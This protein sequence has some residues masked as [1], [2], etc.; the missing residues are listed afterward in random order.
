MA[1]KE[2]KKKKSSHK[3][4]KRKQEDVVLEVE[5]EKPVDAKVTSRSSTKKTAR[6]Q[7]DATRAIV[8]HPHHEENEPS[9]LESL[10][11]TT[12]EKGGEIQPH[13]DDDD[14]DN[15]SNIMEDEDTT[16][17]RRK[18]KRKRA[19]KKD[20]ND[21]DN[22]GVD[23]TEP[24]HVDE[25]EAQVSRTAYMEGLP[26]AAQ[27]EQVREF[28]VQ[29]GCADIQDLRLPVWQD[30]GRLRG[31]GHVVFTTES[32]YHKAIQELTGKYIQGRYLT[33]QPALKPKA[34][35]EGQNNT[36]EPSK[37]LMLHNL[38]YQAAEQDIEPVLAKFGTI[39][40]GGVRVVRHSATGQSKGFAYVEFADVD[41]AVAVMKSPS[42]VVIQGRPCR[43]DYDHGRVRGSFRT[44]DRKLWQKEHGRDK[45]KM[46]EE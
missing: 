6:T 42:Q 27:P 22:N 15:D 32:S 29:H 46:V 40:E 14:D 43:L 37:T 20:T 7:E 39:A 30:S 45:K 18:R 44:A 16:K 9:V 33:I 41:S 25:K 10:D 3:K 35:G 31:Y 2:H 8:D 17:K 13:D 36:S 24:D 28:F 1:H 38:S 34:I 23:G 4:E 19:N 12:S 11:T 5:E 26:F 21:N